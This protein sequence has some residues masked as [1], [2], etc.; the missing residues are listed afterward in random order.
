MLQRRRCSPRH[1]HPPE[2]ADQRH[3][4]Q[5]L[6]SQHG[7]QRSYLQCDTSSDAR[8][9]HDTAHSAVHLQRRAHDHHDHDDHGHDRDEHDHQRHLCEA[10][11]RFQVL[12]R[13]GARRAQQGGLLRRRE[14]PAR[15]GRRQRDGAEQRGLHRLPL[16]LRGEHDDVRRHPGRAVRVQ[17]EAAHV[18]VRLQR[19]PHDHDYDN[20]DRH[21]DHSI[22]REV[23]ERPALQRLRPP[24]RA[25]QGGVLRRGGG[26]GRPCREVPAGG[27]LHGLLR[28]RLQLRGRHPD[29]R[30]DA[31]RHPRD[32]DGVPT[33]PVRLRRPRA[34]P[35]PLS[36]AG[37]SQTT[38]RRHDLPQLPPGVICIAG[39]ACAEN[40]WSGSSCRCKRNSWARA[41]LLLTVHVHDLVRL[42]SHRDLARCHSCACSTG[43]MPWN[44]SSALTVRR[45]FSKPFLWTCTGDLCVVVIVDK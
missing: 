10:G 11:A 40:A 12:R 38:L 19:H 35:V 28:V 27:Q 30:P 4:L 5:R 25:L 32:H 41:H 14:A 17:H 8:D 43:R 7:G 39:P 44:A 26:G 2:A 23:G 29:V 18:R 1:Q 36:A 16:Q 34:S 13:G 24:R 37:D 45:H 3:W 6:C 31:G 9:A 21:D 20:G 22:V 33:L 42:K 15:L